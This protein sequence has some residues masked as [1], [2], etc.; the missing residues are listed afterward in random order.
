MVCVNDNDNDK[1]TSIRG[2]SKRGKSC[3][4]RPAD[5][6]IEFKKGIQF[7]SFIHRRITGK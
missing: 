5:L 6:R 1:S 7:N 2:I 3:I 4:L